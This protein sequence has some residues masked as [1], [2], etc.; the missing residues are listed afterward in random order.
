VPGEQNERDTRASTDVLTENVMGVRLR[1]SMSGTG[2]SVEQPVEQW[3][4]LDGDV[5]VASRSGK[6]CLTCHWMLL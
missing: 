3:P 6:V 4:Y 5:L 1:R 2:G